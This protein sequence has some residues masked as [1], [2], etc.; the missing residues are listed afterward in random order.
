[1][2]LERD[3]SLNP[4]SSGSPVLDGRGRVVGLVVA[5][6]DDGNKQ[7]QALISAYGASILESFLRQLAPVGR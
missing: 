6:K 2:V 4:G 1:M 7:S 3:G 5:T